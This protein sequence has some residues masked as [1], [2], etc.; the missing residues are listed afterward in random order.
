M[1]V[2]AQWDDLCPFMEQMEQTTDLFTIE[3]STLERSLE[4]HLGQ[5]HC[6]AAY[7]EYVMDSSFDSKHPTPRAQ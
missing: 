1:C 3:H 6:E 7:L 5:P 4:E 2:L